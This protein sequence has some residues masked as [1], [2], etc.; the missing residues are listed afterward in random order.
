MAAI[1][2][3]VVEEVRVGREVLGLGGGVRRESEEG[4]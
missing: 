3:E 2:R 1:L 4:S